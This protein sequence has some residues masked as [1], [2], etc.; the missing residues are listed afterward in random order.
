MF[1][2]N[3]FNCFIDNNK[4]SDSPDTGNP[5]KYLEKKVIF[6]IDE[7]IKTSKPGKTCIQVYKSVI[8]HILLLS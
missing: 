7:L 2:S 5:E 1:S 4:F 8:F 3:I 6:T